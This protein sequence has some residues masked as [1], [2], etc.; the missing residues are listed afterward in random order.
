MY[1]E[2]IPSC[3]KTLGEQGNKRKVYIKDLPN[4][5]LV[6]INNLMVWEFINIIK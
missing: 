5:K 2:K 3:N 1:G 6:K 4:L